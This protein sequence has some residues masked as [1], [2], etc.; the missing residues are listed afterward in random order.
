MSSRFVQKRLKVGGN[1]EKQVGV[2]AAIQALDDL[3]PSGYGNYM[4]QAIFEFG[5]ASMKDELM[6]ALYDRDV[7]NLCLHMHGCRVIQ[8]AIRFLK[9]EHVCTLIKE[10]HDK[11][12]TFIH[13]PHGNHVIQRCVQVMSSFAKCAMKSD[14]PE[15]AS[16]L[17]DQMQFIIDDIVA[18]VE[19]LSTHRYG[20]RVV[21][22]AIEHC[23]EEQKTLGL[24]EVFSCHKKL[25]VDQYGNYVA[26][27]AL[28]CGSEAHQTA[29]VDTLTEEN[30]SLLALSRH[31]YA[32]NVVEAVLVHGRPQHKDA[33]LE[34]MLRDTRE[35]GGEGYCCVIELAK[36]PIANYVVNKAIE[37]SE[38]DQKKK[39]LEVIS[40]GRQELSKSPYAKYVLQRISKLET[41]Q[42]KDV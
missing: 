33:I 30:D 31:K 29:I 12:V 5:T 37:V 6:D 2:T 19:I 7:V 26:Q 17:S 1:D 15:L 9:Q 18:N 41:V 22:R 21:Q 3:W 39:F 42:E 10:F 23:V 38:G 40:S 13:D 11:V 32:S 4:L 25:V 35:E 27:Q 8:K 14:N 36:D 24:D 34:Q 20:C 28:I 16:S